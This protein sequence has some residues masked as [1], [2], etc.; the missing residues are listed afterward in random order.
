MTSEPPCITSEGITEGVVVERNTEGYLSPSWGKLPQPSIQTVSTKRSFASTEPCIHWLFPTLD[1]FDLS[2][3]DSALFFFYLSFSLPPCLFLYLCLSLSEDLLH[4][5]A[6]NKS[7]HDYCSHIQVITPCSSSRKRSSHHTFLSDIYLSAFQIHLVLL[8]QGAKFL[9]NLKRWDK[10]ITRLLLWHF[11]LNLN[12]T[13]SKVHRHL[14][15]V[16]GYLKS[17]PMS[18]SWTS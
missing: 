12:T 8:L 2:G 6:F 17:M 1:S 14:N 15:K 4:S 16:H 13:C 7:K 3:N 10:I 5:S 9:L 11:C 18:N